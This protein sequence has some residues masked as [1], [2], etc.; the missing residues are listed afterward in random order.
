MKSNFVVV[1]TKGGPGKSIISMMVIPTFFATENRK[2]KIFSVD[3]NN[4]IKIESNFI[5]FK[6]LM[7]KDSESVI[8]EV[9]ITSMSKNDDIC[10]I[11]SG[12]GTD[13]RSL[14]KVIKK[15]EIKGLTYIIPLMDDI[16]QIHNLKETIRGIKDASPDA[17]IYL[18]L[19]QIYE[20]TEEKIKEQF[21]GLFGSKKYMLDPID[22]NVMDDIK[23]VYFLSHSPIFSL[24]KNVHK[25]SLLDAY[26]NALDLLEGLESKKK[27]WILEG[28]EY[29]KKQNSLVRLA[30]D[31][32][33]LT[34]S[35]HEM[36]TM[37]E[38]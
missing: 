16:E 33:S 5:D 28:E 22:K 6:E 1:S 37:V 24:L 25:T 29:F 12:G 26:L 7:V 10:I 15:T 18:I 17:D 30:K 23:E 38:D 9:E 14:L 11:D 35:V 13:T 36:K 8:D 3:D 20:M 21:L 2:I 34:E 27:Q 32:V 31:V 4:K 19:N